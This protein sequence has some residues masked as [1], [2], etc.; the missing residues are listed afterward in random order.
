ME[1]IQQPEYLSLPIEDVLALLSSDDLNVVSERSVCEAALEWLNHDLA[2]RRQY[3]S[4][5]LAVVRLPCLS[6]EY[7]TDF[8]DS[9]SLFREDAE[10]QMLLKEAMK[11]H[12]LPDRRAAM[13]LGERARPRKSTVGT[14]YIIGGMDPN[15]GKT[16][17]FVG[18][19]LKGQCLLFL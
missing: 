12:L 5:L 7:L 1:V 16:L 8:V 2:N 13:N 9:N 10:C 17:I 14:L 11:F 18:L 3:A 4:R 15:K 6:P 19:T